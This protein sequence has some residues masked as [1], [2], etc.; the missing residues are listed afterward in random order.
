[1]M[2]RILIAYICL[3]A[4]VI[5][6]AYAQPMTTAD[7]AK[8]YP[9]RTVVIESD[10][11]TIEATGVGG[12]AVG[13]DAHLDQTHSTPPSINMPWGG[14]AG[15]SSDTSLSA[16]A[17]VYGSIAFRWIAGIVGLLSMLGGYFVGRQGN[18][19]AAAIY[20][21]TGLGL[22]VGT[23]FFPEWLE[24]GLLA[25]L[26]V[27]LIQYARDHGVLTGA[28]AWSGVAIHK[29]D[30]AFPGVAAAFSEKVGGTAEPNEAALIN[31]VAKANDAS[32]VKV[33]S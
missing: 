18:L 2:T 13:A 17:Q 10:K 24:L 1:M 26:V 31:K 20:A 14:G 23:I 29:L 15:G 25:F 6:I 30:S 12:Q 21:G 7:L 28:I 8:Q 27:H 22:L 4:A 3:C 19:R 11:T 5:L 33:V 16:A 9:G 32:S